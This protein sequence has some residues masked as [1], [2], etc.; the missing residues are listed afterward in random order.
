MLSPLNFHIYIY[1][2]VEISL[3]AFSA[4]FIENYF[5]WEF[6]FF[7]STFFYIV[8]F[9]HRHRCRLTRPLHRQFSRIY[10]TISNMNTEKKQVAKRVRVESAANIEL[11]IFLCMKKK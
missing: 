9:S 10:E 11:N 5:E 4:S 2:E 6:F 3:S 7:S 8:F 1:N